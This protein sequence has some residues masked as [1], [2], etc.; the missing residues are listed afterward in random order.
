MRSSVLD[1]PNLKYEYQ[2]QCSTRLGA[3]FAIHRPVFSQIF[4]VRGPF[5]GPLTHPSS[6]LAFGSPL[7]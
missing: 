1:Q 2:V 6:G 7:K 4:L 3:R 5:T